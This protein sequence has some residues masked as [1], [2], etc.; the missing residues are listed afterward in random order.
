MT[1]RELAVV[2]V[3]AGTAASLTHSVGWSF[4]CLFLVAGIVLGLGTGAACFLN[5][6]RDQKEQHRE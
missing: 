2:L 3:T 6:S 1:W 4:M 5:G